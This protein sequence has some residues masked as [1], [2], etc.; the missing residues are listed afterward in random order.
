MHAATWWQRAE[1]PASWRRGFWGNPQSLEV[2][3]GPS[4][5]FL[6][7]KPTFLTCDEACMFARV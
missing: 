3:T 4:E 7:P 1:K 6:R 2:Q 5:P